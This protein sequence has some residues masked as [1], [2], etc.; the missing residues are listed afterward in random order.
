MDTKRF[1]QLDF[2]IAPRSFR[3]S[4][5]DVTARTDIA[6][7]SDHALVTAKI[8]IKLKHGT[9]HRTIPKWNIIIFES[10]SISIYNQT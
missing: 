7:N 2:V 3:N 5:L 9:I 10:D 6:F 1:A 8:R 4:I